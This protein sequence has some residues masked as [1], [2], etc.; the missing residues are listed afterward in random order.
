MSFTYT[1][2]VVPSN[3]NNRWLKFL[4]NNSVKKH[5]KLPEKLLV[6]LSMFNFTK[7]FHI[8]S[9]ACLIEEYHLKNVL[10]KFK[11]NKSDSDTYLEKIRFFEYWEKGFNR[12]K[13]TQTHLGTALCLWKINR[14]MIYPYVHFAEQY[15]KNNF[16]SGKDLQGLNIAL[17]EV[18]NNIYDHSKS[19]VDGYVFTQYFPNIHRIKIAVCDFGIGIPRAVN[20]YLLSIRKKE[21][22]NEE[23]LK[24]AFKKGFSTYSA[25]HNRGFGLDTLKSI[26]M[27][28]EGE[29]HFYSNDGVVKMYPNGDIEINNTGV[30]FEGTLIEVLLDTRCLPELELETTDEEFTF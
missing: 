10:I 1:L 20:E 30:E 28:L 12:N 29:I 21:I 23:A 24:L 18:F 13:Y 5:G 8:V 3:S 22:S 4:L 9:L 15:F 11:R 16:F 2:L 25:P 7:P 17:A 27:D 26:V 14:E 6:D 19:P